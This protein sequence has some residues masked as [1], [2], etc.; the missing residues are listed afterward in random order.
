M[1][2]LRHILTLAVAIVLVGAPILAQT[3]PHTSPQNL[4]PKT[5]PE[6]LV[7]SPQIVPRQPTTSPSTSPFSS[8]AQPSASPTTPGSTLTDGDRRLNANTTGQVAPT[9]REDCNDW[10]KHGFKDEGAC[11]S[12]LT[13][14]RDRR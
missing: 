12:S 11:I 13:G 5:S 9:N 6:P 4:Q 2:Q 8:P 7:T 14:G 3:Q 1:K 10:Q